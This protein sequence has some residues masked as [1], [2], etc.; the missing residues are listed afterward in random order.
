MF[1]PLEVKPS[2]DLSGQGIPLAMIAVQAGHG[3]LDYKRHERVTLP[4]KRCDKR[5]TETIYKKK[6]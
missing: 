2:T 3:C 5:R 4:S 6:I 1:T